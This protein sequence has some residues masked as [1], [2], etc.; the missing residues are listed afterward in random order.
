VTDSDAASFQHR[1]ATLALAACRDHGFA[2][3]GGQALIAHGI[4]NRATEDIDIFTDDPAG[5][6]RAS[7]AVTMALAAAGY[8]VESVSEMAEIDEM[9]SGFGDDL[10]ELEISEGERIVRLQLARFDR[11]RA[12]VV[13]EIGPILHVD[14]VLGSKVAA[15]ATRAEPRDYIDVAAALRVRSAD[16]LRTLARQADPALSEDELRAAMARL[17]RLDDSVFIDLYGLSKDEVNALRATFAGWPR[18]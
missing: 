11:H 16:E 1:V 8:A 10:A 15:L 18:D 6:R 13:M 2:L 4:V 14:D 12:P 17:D 3:A 7:E 5:V 9:F